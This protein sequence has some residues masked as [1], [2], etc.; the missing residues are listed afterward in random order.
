V[1]DLPGDPPL[2]FVGCAGSIERSARRA[3]GRYDVVLGGAERFRILEELPSSGER[4]YR[5]ARVELLTDRF[6]EERE[7][8]P[9]QALR[10]DVIDLLS[11]LLRLVAPDKAIDPRRFSGMD[12]LTFVNLLCQAIELPAAEKQGLLEAEGPLARCEQLAA[13]LQ[14]RLAEAGG[15]HVG[16]TRTIH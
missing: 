6:D 7:G 3:D 16:P 4:L 12:D 9:L 10:A 1:A 5:V 8:I 13:L 15:G 14:F 2:F 11:Q